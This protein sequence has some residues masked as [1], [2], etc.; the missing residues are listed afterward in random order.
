[1]AT[2]T[3][4]RLAK[5]EASVEILP[6]LKLWMVNSSKERT[7]NHNEIIQRLTK[8]ETRHLSFEDYQKKCDMD[9]ASI[10]DR[11][12]SL[13]TSRTRQLGIATGISTAITTAGAALAWL[14][15]K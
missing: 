2:D 8:M 5:I 3:E 13:E 1:M 10:D 12:T 9:R 6:D 15:A 4:R 14:F 7:L 11:V